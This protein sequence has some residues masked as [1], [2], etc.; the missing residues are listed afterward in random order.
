MLLGYQLW[1]QY[2]THGHELEHTDYKFYAPFAPY[3]NADSEDGVGGCQISTAFQSD[4][5]RGVTRKK[6]RFKRGIKATIEINCT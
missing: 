1:L 5:G 6:R 4:N 3:L 2:S